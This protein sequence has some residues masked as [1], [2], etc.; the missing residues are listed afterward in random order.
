M[1]LQLQRFADSGD[2]TERATPKR[3]EEA[4]RKGNVSRSPELT[5]ALVLAA[6][7]VALRFTGS[8]IWGSWQSLMERD[9]TMQVPSQWTT[10]TVTQLLLMQGAIAVK[11]LLPVVGIALLIGVA[12]SV[13]QVRP[14]FVPM[15]LAP[16]FSRIQPL[17]G[18]KR[19]F[20]THTLVELSKSLLKLMLIG[21]VGYSVVVPSASEIRG[22]TQVDVTQLPF[23]VGGMVFSLGIRIAVCMVMLAF[24]DFLYQRFEYERGL[25]MTKQEVKDEMKQMEGN[26]QIKGV[27][28][29]RARQLAFRRMM[30]DVP[31][32]DVVVTNPTHFAIALK[33]DSQSMAAPQVIAKG[34]DNLAQRIKERAAEFGVPMVE[35]R[36]LAQTLYRVAEVGDAVPQELYQAVAEVLA[37]VYRLKQSARG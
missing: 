13:A 9:L 32:A 24:F 30:Q 10:S 26:Q 5:S 14:M 33:Y 12:V 23:A 29:R 17:A 18:L 1:D 19:M 8:M 16:K 36:P 27:I 20:S 11:A 37:H 31:K 3:R 7:L 34:A 35:N 21:F 15:L 4:R 6:I 22:F 2:K 28:R 25:R